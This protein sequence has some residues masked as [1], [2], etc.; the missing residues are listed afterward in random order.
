MEE[1]SPTPRVSVVIPT[2]NR[3][4]TLRDAVASVLAQRF[5]SLE[6][7]V[8]DDGS[9]DGTG[10]LVRAV[11]DPRVRYIAR[12]HAGVSSAR[13]AGVQH[14][15]GELLAFLD[16]DDVWRPDKLTHEVA[17]LDRHREADAV[18][19]DLEKLDGERAYASFMRQTAVFSR[20]LRDRRYPDGL[21]LS[22]REMRLILLEE[23][24]IKPSA[25]TL[26]RAAFERTGGFDEGWSSSED[27]EFLLR[28]ARAH[29]IGYLDRPLAVLRVGAD[30]LHRVD[31]ARGEQAMIR[32]LRRERRLLR[33]DREAVA[34]VQRGL[35]SRV[36]HFGWHYLD[37]GRPGAAA[38]VLVRGFLLTRRPGLLA[39]A[40]AALLPRRPARGE[41][42]SAARGDAAPPARRATG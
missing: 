42:R 2:Y 3:A 14:A 17:F 12:E 40:A 8:V 1:A 6:L 15:R 19:S 4:H 23:V 11:R 31:Q 25:L 34:A 36:K 24:P 29:R 32:L 16:S 38:R 30:S 10:A 9:T 41:V 5:R 37:T 26:R 33:G 21:M 22:P 28:F 7:L 13:N 18:F 20:Y 35:V 27:W 39:R